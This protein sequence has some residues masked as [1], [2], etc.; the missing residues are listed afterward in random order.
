METTGIVVFART[1]LV[2]FAFYVLSA[3]DTDLLRG[4]AVWESKCH[5]PR[6]FLRFALQG[7]GGAPI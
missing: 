6:L 3:A 2:E 7:L 5:F 1:L 4:W